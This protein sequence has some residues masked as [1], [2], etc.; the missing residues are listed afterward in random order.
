MKDILK[1][2]KAIL[3]KSDRLIENTVVFWKHQNRPVITWFCV[4]FMSKIDFWSIEGAL[5][6]LIVFSWKNLLRNMKQWL[7]AFFS[8]E[9][10]FSCLRNQRSFWYLEIPVYSYPNSFLKCI[11][12]PIFLLFHYFNQNIFN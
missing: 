12:L 2:V 10:F 8:K 3:L 4:D 7:H 11:D 9:V 5:L 6:F 1:T